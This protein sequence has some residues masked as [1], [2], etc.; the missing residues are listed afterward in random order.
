MEEQ[1]YIEEKVGKR[2]PFR[3][4]D[5]YFDNFAAQMMQQLPEKPE[6]KAQAKQVWLR[7]PLYYAAACIAVLLISVTAW[8]LMPE[9]DMQTTAPTQMAAQ[10]EMTD[11][12]LDQAADYLMLDNHDIYALLSEN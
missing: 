10:Q 9:T 12:D 1:K 3:V 7:K 8:L 5:G 4:P 6:R 2:N 11:E